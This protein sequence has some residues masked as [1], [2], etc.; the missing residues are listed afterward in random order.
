MYLF[1]VDR[2]SLRTRL[3]LGLSGISLLVVGVTWIL[4]GILLEDLARD[5]LGDRLQREAD[6]SIEVLEQQYDTTTITPSS[7]QRRY[8][9][10]HHL[11]VLR[12]GEQISS[13]DEH[14]R[15]TL[16]PLLDQQGEELLEFKEGDQHLLIYRHHFTLNGAAGVLLMGE[17]FSQ[18]EAGLGRLHW[19]VAGIAAGLLVLLMVLNLLAINGGLIPLSRI[20]DELEELQTG[21]RE[22]LSTDVPS[23]L[24]RLVAQLN[25][26]LDEI[27][28]RLQ[29]SRDS[30]ANLS[31]A[32]KTP[33]AAVTQVLR[34]ERPIDAERRR[35]LVQRLE[36]IHRQLDAELRRARIAGPNAGRFSH[37]QRDSVRLIEMFRGLYPEK[38]FN[39]MLSAEAERSVAIESQDYSEMLGIVL[40]NAG[41][42]A[43]HEIQCQ[44]TADAQVSIV[45]ED[46]GSGVAI[47]DL[48]RLGQRGL[49]LDEQYPGYGLG[50]SILRQLVKRY[51]GQLRFDACP[52]GGLRVE[53]T[54]PLKEGFH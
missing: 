40:D 33:L 17:D 44:L 35:K 26:F 14:W 38:Q 32:L 31:H 21:K 30:V 12:V 24:D 52:G 43:R 10:L 49:R 8:R 4:H 45:V 28:R 6:H 16:A 18:V 15:E 29:R 34:G 20:R 53:I 51:S 9:I 2:R 39:L 23:E 37:L 19:W 11:Y 3:L 5:F 13:S 27:D 50:L 46:D 42:W 25:H 54:I 36:D 48:P 1:R 7:S 47:D 41:K 22:R